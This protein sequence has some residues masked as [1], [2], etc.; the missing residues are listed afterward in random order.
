M[1]RIMAIFKREFQAYFRSP[2]G[3]VVFAIFMA[4]S[5][6]YFASGILGSYVDM[7]G[8]ISFVQSFLFI[9]IPLL[10][11]RTFSEDRR[12]GTEVLLFTSPASTLEIVLGKYLAALALFVVMTAGTFTHL[13]IAYFYGGL[14]D[15]SVLGAYIGFIF[16]GVAYVSI[17][18]FAS[19]LT[20]NQI[21][22][23]VISFVIMLMLM[24]LDFVS[25]ML[26]SVASTLIDKINVFNLSDTKISEIGTAVTDAIQWLNPM[27]RLNNYVSGIFEIAPILFFVSLAAAF[28][29]LTNRILEKRRW[30]QR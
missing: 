24:L 30:S 2:I 6:L 21:I 14:L 7:V 15:V 20:E 13:V 4:V 11:M 16:L 10:T 3:F 28:V 8:E 25:S 1:T 9:I 5:G 12:N 23:A 18:C 22:A 17:G 27:T 29:Y 26:G 19:A